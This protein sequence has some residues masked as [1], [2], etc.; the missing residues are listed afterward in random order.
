MQDG[1]LAYVVSAESSILSSVERLSKPVPGSDCMKWIGRYSGKQPRRT[2]IIYFSPF[3][4]YGKSLYKVLWVLSHREDL[5]KNHFVMRFC[6]TPECCNPRHLI[7]VPEESQR[8]FIHMRSVGLVTKYVAL[9]E[10]KK[11]SDKLLDW[12]RVFKKN[13][14]FDEG[15]VSNPELAYSKYKKEKDV[16][17]MAR[18][19]KTQEVAPKIVEDDESFSLSLSEE[20]EAPVFDESEEQFNEKDLE[21]I[22]EI[23]EKIV[24]KAREDVDVSDSYVS[25]KVNIESLLEEFKKEVAVSIS[26]VLSAI[27]GIKDSISELSSQ[28]EDLTR[29]DDPAKILS[30]IASTVDYNTE[31]LSKIVSSVSSTRVES[32]VVVEDTKQNF[33]QDIVDKVRKWVSTIPKGK[34]ASLNTVVT[35]INKRLN[36]GIESVL[37]VIKS[38]SDIVRVDTSEGRIYSI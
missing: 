6:G 21:E 34:S 8:A 35:E 3:G 17:T 33:S 37:E 24:A 31:S 22:T 30:Y 27:S 38:Q 32:P 18:P 5:E 23:A 16:K 29:R 4:K 12:Y 2:P 10:F 28:V 13:N 25:K 1:L 26:G 11:T 9:W 20:D 7:S 19:K 15:K 14:L 36:I